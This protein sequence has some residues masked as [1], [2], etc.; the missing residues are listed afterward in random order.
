M[1]EIRVFVK[2]VFVVVPKLGPGKLVAPEVTKVE[3]QTNSSPFLVKLGKGVPNNDAKQE[4]SF[5]R[6]L[7]KA[8]KHI[9]RTNFDSVTNQGQQFGGKYFFKEGVSD[10]NW[11]LV[12]FEGFD[13]SI[14]VDAVEGLEDIEADN[15]ESQA[16]EKGFLC[17][18]SQSMNY[19]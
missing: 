10:P 4:P 13:D 2:Q 7:S 1:G 6:T 19:L 3:S 9:Y 18:C 15:D 8:S 12:S 5:W 16:P 14:K 11:Y 17:D